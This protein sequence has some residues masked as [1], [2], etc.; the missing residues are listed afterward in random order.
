VDKKYLESYEMWCWRRMQ[1]V[2]WTDRV[3]NKYYTESSR[4]NYPTCNKKR[5]NVKWTGQI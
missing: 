1:K 2:G 5:R 3:N 4:N